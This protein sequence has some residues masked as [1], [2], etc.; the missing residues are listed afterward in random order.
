MEVF[1]VCEFID[2]NANRVAYNQCSIVLGTLG[3]NG[4]GFPIVKEKFPYNVKI[5]DSFFWNED[6]K[7]IYRTNYQW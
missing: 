3:E 6:E 5:G 1:T 4:L 2:T 7:R